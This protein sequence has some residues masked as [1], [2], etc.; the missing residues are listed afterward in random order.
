MRMWE[1]EDLELGWGTIFTCLTNTAQCKFTL[2]K[3]IGRGKLPRTSNDSA[4]LLQ[5]ISA[6]LV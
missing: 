3:N 4:L 6:A 2:C 5:L 1:Q